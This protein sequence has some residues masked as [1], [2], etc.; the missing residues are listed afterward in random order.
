MES[1]QFCLFFF[2]YIWTQWL[3]L[4]WQNEPNHSP[5]SAAVLP[6]LLQDLPH[7]GA[8]IVHTLATGRD[9]FY[10]IRLL[11]APFNLTLNTFNNEPSTSSLSNLF[12]CLA[13]HIE[14]YFFLMSNL[15]LRSCSL[16]LFPLVL[17]LQ[18]LVISRTIPGEQYGRSHQTWLPPQFL[19]SS[20]HPRAWGTGGDPGLAFWWS[21]DLLF[22]RSLDGRQLVTCTS[23]PLPLWSVDHV[24]TAEG[25]VNFLGL[26]VCSCSSQLQSAYTAG[27]F[28]T[29]AAI[30]GQ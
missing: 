14:K 28:E 3:H 21:P 4:H 22:W 8:V 26:C 24:C 5:F 19:S 29:F 1:L 6:A 2:F 10:L 17:S 16:K 25:W 23:A 15:N 7:P 18:A 30:Y 13:I 11:K 12:W 20:H 9:M 27:C